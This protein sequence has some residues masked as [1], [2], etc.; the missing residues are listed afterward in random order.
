MCRV[1]RAPLRDYP[2]PADTMPAGPAVA[3]AE[4]ELRPTRR[5]GADNTWPAPGTVAGHLRLRLDLRRRGG[6]AAPDTAAEAEAQVG[7]VPMKAGRRRT[8]PT[9]AQDRAAGLK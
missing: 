1:W 2:P 6:A 3:A 9:C 5:P 4:L 7:R 8:R